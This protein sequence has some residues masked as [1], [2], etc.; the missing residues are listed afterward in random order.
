MGNR[1]I[2]IPLFIT[3]MKI[4]SIS[5]I[6]FFSITSS[7]VSQTKQDY[8]WLFG[9]DMS[10]SGFNGYIFDFNIPTEQVVEHDNN[11]G[12]G[13]ANTSICN[14]DGNLLFYFN[15][16]AVMNRNFEMMPDGDRLSYN[17]IW[18]LFNLRCDDG[19]VG[20]FQDHLILTDPADEDEYYIL[21]KPFMYNGPGIID[22]IQLWYSKVD[23]TK[24]GGLGDVTL[25]NGIFDDSKIFLSSY[26][27]AINHQNGSDWWVLQA[28]IEDSVYHTYL[29]DSNGFRLDQIQ[30]SHHFMTRNRTSASGTAKFSPDG[31][32][33]AFYNYYDQLHIYDFDRS[34]GILSNHKK[35]E[36]I[37]DP[38]YNN[39]LFS[40]LEFSPNSRFIYAASS[41]VLYQVDLWEEDIQENGIRLIDTY[42]GT[43]DPFSTTFFLMAQA[44][45]CK[46][47]MCPTSGTRSYH[48]IKKPNE[49]GIA[50]DFVQNGVNLPQ[51]S[52]FGGMPNFPRFRVD[53]EDKC[54]PT[55]TSVFGDAV[56]Y[57][58][59]LTVY[60]SPSDG[61]YTIEVPDDFRSGTLSVI[62]L[63]GQVVETK[64]ISDGTISVAV[65]ITR[66]PSGY[67]HVEL[68]PEENVERVFWSKQV[69][70]Q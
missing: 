57:R 32:K 27:T 5:I 30:N 56:Y 2:L 42:N 6:L 21:H 12:I 66:Y 59:D 48:V 29:I 16:C 41:S 53:E 36:I 44:P 17:V 24:E 11:I 20:S 68:Y 62:N 28:P 49:L 40:S 52:N 64:E 15:G 9:Q 8:I 33:Y 37:E 69:M 19:T 38:D 7:L 1:L 54:D 3:I 13:N 34:T 67:Y 47:Y 45:D 63:D 65:D 61:R 35:I 58:R 18:Q 31:T 51:L 23:M 70:K 14:Q 55:L 43:Q 22:S 10:T 60:P 50:C 26:L 46:I 25:K 39:L 4:L